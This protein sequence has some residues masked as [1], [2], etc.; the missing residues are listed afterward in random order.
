MTKTTAK[1]KIKKSTQ[2][3]DKYTCE[4]CGLVVSVDEICGCMDF[5]DIICC[6]T[7]MK[8]KKK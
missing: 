5:C 6:N 1:R 8:P 4:I 3:G 7:H 2:K